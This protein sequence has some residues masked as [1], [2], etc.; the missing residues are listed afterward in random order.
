MSRN[1]KLEYIDKE[2]NYHTASYKIYGVGLLRFKEAIFYGAKQ[3]VL[4]RK[5]WVAVAGTPFTKP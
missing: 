2:G 1:Y 3:A 4:S 5:V